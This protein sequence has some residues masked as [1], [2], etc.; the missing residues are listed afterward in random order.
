[1][2]DPVEKYYNKGYRNL[3]KLHDKLTRKGFKYSKSE[4]QKYIDSRHVKSRVKKYNKALMGNKFSGVTNTWQI[5]TY[6]TEKYKT[7]YLLAINV[8]TRYVWCRERDAVTSDNFIELMDEFISN[9]HPKII[10]CD[11]EKSFTSFQSVNFLRK[12]NII[13]KVFNSKMGHEPM[14]ILNKFCRY[15]RVESRDYDDDPPIENIVKIYN[16]SFHSSINMEPREMQNN[17]NN[18]LWYIYNQLKIRDE[19]N[20]LSLDDPIQQGDYVRYIRDE[21]RGAKKF[22]KDKMKYQ[23]SK[24]YYYVEAK[25]S[26][27]SYDILARDGSVKTVP[28]YKLYKITPSE[29]KLLQFAPKMEDENNFQI[30]DEIIRYDYKWKSND[31][32]IDPNKSKYTVRVISRD[33]DGNK[34]K[35]EYKYSINQLRETN[36]TIPTK[37]EIEFYAKNKDKFHFDKETGYL[38]PI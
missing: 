19:K 22:Q 26:E 37:L 27:L 21:D 36:P 1:M 17:I 38:E 5:D 7:P 32:C 3:K 13:M 30:F 11:A 28:R 6:I 24:Y 14:S 9:Y 23:L 4:V 8:N 31:D 18:E 20:K 33:D 15:L 29:E 25:N 2:E 16:K 34:I 12:H 35:H 10:E